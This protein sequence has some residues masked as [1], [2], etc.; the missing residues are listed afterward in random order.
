MLSAFHATQLAQS[1]NAHLQ[2]VVAVW[3][4]EVLRQI[5]SSHSQITASVRHSQQINFTGPELQRSEWEVLK[6]QLME[7]NLLLIGRG[8]QA[9]V[10]G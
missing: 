1:L 6:L 4:G 9:Q 10:T 8:V 3:R 7:M 2:G 5:P